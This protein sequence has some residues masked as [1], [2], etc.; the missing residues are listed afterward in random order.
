MNTLKYF[1]SIL[2]IALPYFI[3][4]QCVTGYPSDA[5]VFGLN[6]TAVWTSELDAIGAPDGVGAEILS[7]VPLNPG[8]STSIIS[9][10]DFGLNIPCNAVID[11]VSF[12]VTR[13][14]NSATG[15]II[16]E[17]INL[18]YGNFIVAT[19]NA[20]IATPWLNST[21]GWETYRYDPVGGWGVALTPELIN[22]FKL[23]FL[24]TLENTSTTEVGLPEID[25]IE[26]EVC[27]TLVGSAVPPL[28]ATVTTTPDNLCDPAGN[29]SITINATGGTGTYEYS[30]DD[31]ATWQ[32]S[33][34][35]TALSSTTYSL[36]VRNTDMSC[37]TDIGARYDMSTDSR[38]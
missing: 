2:I 29:G 1:V 25:A 27:Y 19:V 36:R 15:S 7:F 9:T 12:L 10:W 30:I 26:I 23:G 32:A 16:D 24:M 11:N 20:G 5:G 28:N 4:G 3:T 6:N 34:T 38:K 8:A 21:T 13:R 22:D 17:N 14:N 35:F 33:N 18:R 31:G 37:S